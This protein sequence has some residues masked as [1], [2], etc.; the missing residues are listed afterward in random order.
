MKLSPRAIAALVLYAGIYG[1]SVAVLSAEPDFEAGEA[2]AVMLIFGLGLSVVAWLATIKGTPTPADIRAPGREFGVLCA[3]LALLAFVFL[4]WGLSAVR[5][6]SPDE[7]VQSIAILASKLAALVIVPAWL[8]TR[9]GYTWRELLAPRSPGRSGM[10]ALF[11]IGVLLLALQLLVGR[12]PETIAALEQPV[13]TVAALAPF[14]FAWMVIEAGLTEEFLF[15]AL[16]QSRAAAWLRSETAGI[17]VM[18]LAFGLAHA[19]GYVLRGAHVME[20]MSQTPDALGA[21]A[22]T[23]VVVSPVGLMFGVLW[24]RTRNLWL[25]ALLHGWGDLVPNL[26][27][28]VTVWAGR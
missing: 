17:I 20:G 7:P 18:A 9:L 21:A 13:S 11:V 16:F 28:F 6:M 4:G 14:A 12:G 26:A 24:A 5:A 3:Y 8:F 2:L 25:L 15:R 1:G 19:P 27:P 10:W 23:V 22:Y